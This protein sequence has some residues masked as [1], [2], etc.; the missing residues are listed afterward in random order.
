M[1]ENL[2]YLSARKG[3]HEN[4]FEKLGQLA[5]ESGTPDL[6]EMQEIAREYLL[7]EANIYSTLS[8][9]DFLR[10]ENKG[11]K[12]YVCNGSA[13]LCAGTQPRVKSE[14]KN[15]LKEEEIG[16]M[17]CLGRCHENSAFYYNGQNYSGEDITNIA[18]LIRSKTA[19]Q[20][21]YGTQA[22]GTA[23]LMQNPLTV[24]LFAKQL[25]YLFTQTPDQVLDEVHKAHVRG[26]GGAGF[27]MGFK[28]ETI[29]EAEGKYKFIVCNADEGDPGAYSDRY[30]LEQQPLR[31]LLG[32]LI[33]G[34]VSGANTGVV[35]IRAEYPESQTVIRQSIRELEDLNLLGNNIQNSGFSFV[36]KLIK[37]QG[38]YI[39]GEET[40]LLSSIEGQSPEVRVRPPFPAQQGLF[41]MPTLVNSV[42]TFANVPFIVEHGGDAFNR[43]G[44][45]QSKGTKLI[46]LDGFFNRPGIYEVEMGTPLKTVIEE[47]GSGFKSDVKALHIG[48]ILGGLVPVSMINSL[49]VSFE[50]FAEN[51]FLL[52]HGSIVSIPEN[53]P[54]I[55][56]I[57]HLFQFT[58]HESCGK[59]FPCRLGSTRGF[60]L[61]QKATDSNY[62]IDRQ[63]FSDLLDTMQQGS[64][65][66]LGGGLPLPVKNALQG[67]DN[68]LKVYFQ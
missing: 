51:G 34:Y 61:L 31:V 67:F 40:A 11:K 63:L 13:C 68:E 43:I 19:T 53:F 48:G 29:K 18:S 2:S 25:K 21:T 42:E 26:R 3:L 62:K 17:T 38:A 47:L 66:A 54:I 14:L 27:P 22:Q 30:L 55:E 9:Y 5:E 24:E 10:P 35:Y 56:Y 15:H 65:C 44:S 6:Q 49:Q 4:L 58:A 39:C 1:S 52:G 59:C 41:N 33:A 36:F 32:M 50:S 45:S 46:S 37:A 7:G 60:E 20:E 57:K 12:A 16:E 8:F 28:L 23:I 64:L